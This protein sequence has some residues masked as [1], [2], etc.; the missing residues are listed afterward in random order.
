MSKGE[1]T[2]ERGNAPV[3]AKPAVEHISN[4]EEFRHALN[5]RRVEFGMSFEELDA[6]SGLADRY[7]AKILSTSPTHGGGTRHIGPTAIGLLAA[8][9]KVRIRLEPIDSPRGRRA[10]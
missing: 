3:L 8:R 2:F 6:R 10:T 7:S 1:R 5:R 4:F 9:A